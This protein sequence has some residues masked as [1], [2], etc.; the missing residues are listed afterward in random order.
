MSSC[1]NFDVEGGRAADKLGILQNVLASVIGVS[2]ATISRMR[3]RTFL[4]D[5]GGGKG[6]ELAQLLV[7]LYV[8]LDQLVAG[9]EL[10]A[11]AWLTAKNTA[12]GGRPIDLIQTVRGLA[13]VVGYM[14]ARSSSP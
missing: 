8:L 14:R 4:Q 3:K 6:F 1:G 11:R 9:D 2:E 13:E 7:H 12:L 5:R 10:A